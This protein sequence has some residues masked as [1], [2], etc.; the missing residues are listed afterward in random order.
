MSTAP[1]PPCASSAGRA[2]C[3]GRPERRAAA[4]PPGPML[5]AADPVGSSRS[6][7]PPPT[8]AVD[9]GR[10][11]GREFLRAYSAESAREY[12]E[13]I[14]ASRVV[15]WVATTPMSS[16]GPGQRR[17]RRV[18]PRSGDTWRRPSRNDKVRGSNPLSSTRLT[19]LCTL[20]RH[21][22]DAHAAKKSPLPGACA[23]TRLDDTRHRRSACPV[24]PCHR[25]F[26][27]CIRGTAAAARRRRTPATSS[28]R[29]RSPRKEDPGARAPTRSSEVAARHLACERQRVFEVRVPLVDPTVVRRQ[30]D[31]VLRGEGG[32]TAPDPSRQGRRPSPAGR[33]TRRPR[34]SRCR[35]P[36]RRLSESRL[37]TSGPS[38]PPRH[39]RWPVQPHPP[40][41]HVDS[42]DLTALPGDRDSFAVR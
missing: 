21:S 35:R 38:T 14:R 23:G 3:R 30:R 27:R 28:S 42:D 29:D 11:R 12:S 39:V 1:S 31:L 24:R 25:A 9:R 37:G 15:S 4:H 34:G 18:S 2:R 36:R 22:L 6:V 16:V 33:A 8:T 19:R 26:A 13:V 7:K 20:P 5:A 41:R 32:D 17:F 40:A 10:A